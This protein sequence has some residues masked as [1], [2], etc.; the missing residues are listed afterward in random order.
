MYSQ[1]LNVYYVFKIRFLNKYLHITEPRKSIR[2]K[3]NITKEIANN[4]P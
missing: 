2:V 3:I 4:R 1:S